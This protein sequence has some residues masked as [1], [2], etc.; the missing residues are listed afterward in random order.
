MN[1]QT[2]LEDF[3]SWQDIRSQFTDYYGR[4][5]QQYDVQEQEPE[6][7]WALYESGGYDGSA[8][9]IFKQDG[10]WFHVYASHYPCY[11]LED[12]WAPEPFT[13]E[14][15]FAAEKT[16]RK[17]IVIY[18][19]TYQEMFHAWFVEMTKDHGHE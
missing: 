11:G 4:E 2:Y 19:A 7:V 18:S 6:C 17:I 16:S 1:K 3:D 14:D 5:K 8:R 9:V 10:Q 15:Y 12:Q 13:P